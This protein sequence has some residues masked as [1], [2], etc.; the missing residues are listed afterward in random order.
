M[1]ILSYTLSN[2]LKT[3]FSCGVSHIV[4]DVTKKES[5]GV[6]VDDDTFWEVW[7]LYL[8]ALGFPAAADVVAVAVEGGSAT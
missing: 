3:R 8:F 5:S 4:S 2:I 6:D 1:L 7:R